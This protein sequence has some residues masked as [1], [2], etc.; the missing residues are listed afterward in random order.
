MQG[1][2]ITPETA[3][4]ALTLPAGTAR[5]PPMP[6]LYPISVEKYHAMIKAGIITENDRCELIEGLLVEKMGKNRLHSYVTGW[7]IQWFHERATTEWF[8]DSQEPI[9]TLESEPEPDV[10]VI[11]GRRADYPKDH[12]LPHQVLLLVEVAESTLTYDRTVKKRL[13]ARAGIPIYWIV[14]LIEKQVEIHTLPSGSAE[15]P[16][17][18]ERRVVAA[19]EVI[20]VVVD[21]QQIGRITVGEIFPG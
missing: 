8:A 16:D 13:Y 20:E 10:T 6:R 15:N 17:Y 9:T 2:A 1:I 7:I 4:A 11:R 18:A 5:Q 19:S 12:P 14:N 3:T 21:G